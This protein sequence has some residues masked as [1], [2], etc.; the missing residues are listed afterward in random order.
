M[1]IGLWIKFAGG[2]QEE[3]EAANA[4]MGV[5]DEPPVGLIF[6]AAGPMGEDWN[7]IDFWESREL[8]ESFREGRLGP[9]IQQL[10][11]R[12]PGVPE[13]KE[14]PIQNLIKP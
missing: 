5:E 12:A 3:Y 4:Q 2:T 10:G 1:A 8:F 9:A 14:F 7:V 11:D 6:H 13:V